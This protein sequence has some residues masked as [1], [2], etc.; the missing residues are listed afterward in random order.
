MNK[1]LE[2]EASDTIEEQR[3]VEDSVALEDKSEEDLAD[4]DYQ[5]EEEDEDGEDDAE[6]DDEFVT[7]KSYYQS[8]QGQ[9][10]VAQ[11][12]IL[13]FEHLQTINGGGMKERLAIH[14]MHRTLGRSRSAWMSTQEVA[15]TMT[16]VVSLTMGD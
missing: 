10:T 9:T 4:P 2:N 15:Q 13:F 12:L 6:I 3:A 11:L 16:S 7:W 5:S 14:I 8:G 1:S